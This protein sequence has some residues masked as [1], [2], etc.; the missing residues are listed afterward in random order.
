MTEPE[1]TQNQRSRHADDM[2]C[3][4]LKQRLEAGEDSAWKELD[5]KYGK[6]IISDL[7]FIDRNRVEDAWQETLKKVANDSSCFPEK[8]KDDSIQRWLYTVT[9]NNLM[10]MLRK[11][12]RH[13]AAQTLDENSYAGEQSSQ[14]SALDKMIRSEKDQ[15][16]RHAVDG[17]D[18]KYRIVIQRHYLGDEALVDIAK[19]LGISPEAIRSRHFRAKAQLSQMLDGGDND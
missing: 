8:N 15:R 14:S 17:L 3:G 7:S 2:R 1:K 12:K 11:E 19:D 9:R 6:K 10:D 13:R 16:V 5:E 4:D 18:E